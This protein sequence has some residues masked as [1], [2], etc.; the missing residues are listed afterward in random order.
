MIANKSGEAGSGR[1]RTSIRGDHAARLW[2]RVRW[3]PWDGLT[4]K[5]KAWTMRNADPLICHTTG[6][7]VP[8][9][10]RHPRK[11]T[12]EETLEKG[13]EVRPVCLQ[14]PGA[15]GKKVGSGDGKGS[16]EGPWAVQA[17]S[18]PR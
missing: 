14:T 3:S 18:F 16:L 9:C 5:H 1:P 15:G 17:F 7:P 8:G 13:P 2:V 12:C 10:R 6:C 11:H 4:P